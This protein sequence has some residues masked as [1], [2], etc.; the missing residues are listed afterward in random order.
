MT[1][2]GLDPSTDLIRWTF[3]LAS[4]LAPTVQAHLEDLG[5]E[6]FVRDGQTFH[7][8]WEETEV[9]LDAAVEAIWNLA[10]EEF[11]ITQE[12][13]HR[14]ELHILHPEETADED[15]EEDVEGEAAEEPVEFHPEAN[16]L[17][18]RDL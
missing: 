18:I 17:E 9:D 1:T 6:V 16:E 15:E 7:V 4:E 8:F 11:E 13:F 12:E 5:A 2:D 10:G 3:E 14:L